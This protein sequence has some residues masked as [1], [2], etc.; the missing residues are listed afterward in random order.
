MLYMPAPFPAP[1]LDAWFRE[2]A[3][4]Y[5]EL[6]SLGTG[7]GRTGLTQCA[8]DKNQAISVLETLHIISQKQDANRAVSYDLLPA[9]RKSLRQAFEGSGN[10]RSFGVPASQPDPRKVDIA[11]LDNY[12]RTQW[13]NILFYMVGSTVGLSTRGAGGQDVHNA[14]KKLLEIGDFIAKRG[15]HITITRNGFTFVLQ[16]TNTQ[17]WT[18]LIVYLKSARQVGISCSPPLFANCQP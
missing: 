10:H 11:F 7:K 6:G 8:R 5:V 1:D 17:V 4:K 3:K 16:D 18:L 13:E 15:G 9:F 2:D 12:A 14:T